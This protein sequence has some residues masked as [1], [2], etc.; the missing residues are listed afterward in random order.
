MITQAASRD[1]LF[2]IYCRHSAEMNHIHLSALWSC[3][4]KLRRHGADCDAHVEQLV[5]QTTRMLGCFGSRAIANTAHGAAKFG[6]GGSVPSLFGPLAE[7]A[8][9]SIGSFNAQSV[10]NTAWAFATVGE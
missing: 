2:A 1:D 4:G 8:T 9:R 7:A 5:R 6:L 10:A 3:L